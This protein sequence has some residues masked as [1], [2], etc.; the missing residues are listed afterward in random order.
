V[1]THRSLEPVSKSSM[2]VCVG[3]PIC[4]EHRYSET[5]CTSSAVTLS[6]V[7]LP[8]QVT[9]MVFCSACVTFG[10]PPTP[11]VFAL[12]MDV[13]A[14]DLRAFEGR[15]ILSGG[16]ESVNVRMLAYIYSRAIRS[17]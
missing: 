6:V 16:L 13:R 10:R 17:S 7:S 1:T 11:R 8:D 15:L 14:A 3:V 5:F 4:I 9:S 12:V 2:S